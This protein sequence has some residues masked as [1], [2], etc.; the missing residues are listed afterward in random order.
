MYGVGDVLVVYAVAA[1]REVL[2]RELDVVCARQGEA[3]RVRDVLDVVVGCFDNHVRGRVHGA[4]GLRLTTGVRDVPCV[5]EQRFVDEVEDSAGPFSTWPRA[6]KACNL[7]LPCGGGNGIRMRPVSGR[8]AV[9]A[10][11]CTQ[12]G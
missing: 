1:V 3:V 12:E 10:H 4:F 11:R 6:V 9:D 2:E 7:G 5:L 8:M